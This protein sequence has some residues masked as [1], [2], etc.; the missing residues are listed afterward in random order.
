MLWWPSEQPLSPWFVH[1]VCTYPL[2]RQILKKSTGLLLLT[3]PYSVTVL[4][5][6]QYL[7][8]LCMKY[9]AVVSGLRHWRPEYM[10]AS[11]TPSTT[12]TSSTTTTGLT[13]IL[14]TALQ[15]WESEGQIFDVFSTER[16]FKHTESHDS[17]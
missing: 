3:D 9:C 5:S 13:A 12:T 1:V 15:K 10:P 2:G 4:V 16:S 8:L 7:S 17:G 6:V 14:D 11:T